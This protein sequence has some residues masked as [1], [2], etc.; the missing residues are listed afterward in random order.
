M[1]YLV[2]DPCYLLDILESSDERDN[3]WDKCLRSMYSSDT[4]GGYSSQSNYEGVRKILSDA[5]GINV[6]RVSDT[7]FGD[8]SNSIISNS[9]HI[10]VIKDDFFADAGMMCVVE[11]N[12]KLENFLKDDSLGAIFGSDVPISVHVDD[13]DRQWYVLKIMDENGWNLLASSEEPEHDEEDEDEDSS[14]ND[15]YEN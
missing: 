3:L 4:S 7:G 2:T 14:H 5:L 9:E 11:I 12:E 8:W 1:K 13:S 10:K 6:L 15:F